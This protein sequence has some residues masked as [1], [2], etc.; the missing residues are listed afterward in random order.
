MSEKML[1]ALGIRLSQITEQ[2]LA[3]GERCPRRLQDLPDAGNAFEVRILHAHLCLAANQLGERFRPGKVA[4]IAR[5]PHTV[6]AL[7]LL[8]T[9]RA[10]VQ[11]YGLPGLQIRLSLD[12]R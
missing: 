5:N 9:L 12:R 7:D 11:L 1:E 8:K 10:D 2:R 4:G 6:S 3:L